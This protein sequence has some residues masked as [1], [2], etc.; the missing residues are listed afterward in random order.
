MRDVFVSVW[1]HPEVICSFD[2]TNDK[3]SEET[4]MLRRSN[5]INIRLVGLEFNGLL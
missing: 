1:F 3:V 2:K 4:E 5:N